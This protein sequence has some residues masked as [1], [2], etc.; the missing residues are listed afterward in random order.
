MKKNSKSKLPKGYYPAT[1]QDWHDR[2]IVIGT[3][4]YLIHDTPSVNRK[5]EA[6]NTKLWK[7]EEEYDRYY[8]STI[9]SYIRDG[10][11]FIKK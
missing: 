10:I 4:Y 6:R 1:I 5:I 3:K 7:T 8:R 2:K 9:M 11:L